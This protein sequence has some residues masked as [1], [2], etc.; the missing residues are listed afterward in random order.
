MGPPGAEKRR[1]RIMRRVIAVELKYA[2][3]E[4]DEVAVDMA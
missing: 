1:A 2:C 3:S 4:V